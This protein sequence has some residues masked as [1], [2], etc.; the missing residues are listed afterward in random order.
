MKENKYKKYLQNPSAKL[1][2]VCPDCGVEKLYTEYH[3]SKNKGKYYY[4]TGHCKVCAHARATR[5][6]FI[7][8]YNITEAEVYT[9]LE[10]QNWECVICKMKL[11]SPKSGIKKLKSTFNVDHCHKTNTV[12]GLLCLGCNTGLGQFRDDKNLLKMLIII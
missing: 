7:L 12:R 8:N 6:N 3:I 10:K 1:L 11:T 5:K 4:L 9:L 2:K